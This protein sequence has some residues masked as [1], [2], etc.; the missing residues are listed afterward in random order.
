MIR[1]SR[2]WEREDGSVFQETINFN[3]SIGGS[4]ISFTE[5]GTNYSFVSGVNLVFEPPTSLDWRFWA[6]PFKAEILDK[7]LVE[8]TAEKYRE[9]LK[10]RYA[11]I[12]EI[13]GKKK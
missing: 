5:K 13:K 11:E 7:T 3:E 8:V 2:Y 9:F 6:D 4:I 12:D 1:K 10:K